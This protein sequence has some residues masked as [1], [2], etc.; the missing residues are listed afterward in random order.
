M[1]IVYLVIIT[2]GLLGCNK[3]SQLTESQLRFNSTIKEQNTIV[4]EAN[5]YLDK[6][7]QGSISDDIGHLIYAKEQLYYAN[8]V[9]KKAKI[10]GIKTSELDALT[11]RLNKYDKEAKA[12]AIELLHSALEQTLVF[13]RKVHEMPMV[14]LSGASLGSES[15]IAYMGQEYNMALNECC[16]LELKDIEIFLRG[17]N[18]ELAW[19]IKKKILNVETQLSQVLSDSKFQQDYSTQLALL[20]KKLKEK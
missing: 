2:L 14:P 15:M 11:T 20:D 8:E 3:Q 16:L 4:L 6:H 1:R 17:V 13:K 7:L 10:S 19:E 18:D 5:A 12:L 9:M